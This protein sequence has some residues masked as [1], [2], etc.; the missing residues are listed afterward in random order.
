MLNSTNIQ[1]FADLKRKSAIIVNQQ[2]LYKARAS[3][4]KDISTRDFD[5]RHNSKDKKKEIDYDNLTNEGKL[6]VNLKKTI[7]L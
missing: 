3:Y 4:S 2:K 5:Q 6:E 1:F 7:L